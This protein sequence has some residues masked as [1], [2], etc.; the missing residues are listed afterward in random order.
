VNWHALFDWALRTGRETDLDGRAHFVAMAPLNPVQTLGAVLSLEPTRPDAACPIFVSSARHSASS[1]KAAA[2]R[3]KNA[4]ERKYRT[5]VG[6]RAA[7]VALGHDPTS[8]EVK[9]AVASATKTAKNASRRRAEQR[10][11]SEARKRD[12]AAS[13]SKA[14][15]DKAMAEWGMSSEEVAD[16]ERQEAERQRAALR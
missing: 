5:D 9:E 11:A 3:R 15:L 2:T 13:Q 10:A 1:D 16:L 6:V 14:V 7:L 12:R 4:G 8:Q